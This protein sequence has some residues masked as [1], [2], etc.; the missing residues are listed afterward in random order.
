MALPLAAPCRGRSLIARATVVRSD[1]S[2]PSPGTLPCFIHM[3]DT[4]KQD[5]EKVL[6]DVRGIISQQLG[7]DLDKVRPSP[8]R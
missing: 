2:G 8:L 4:H 5:K 3:P 1:G 7:T 6:A